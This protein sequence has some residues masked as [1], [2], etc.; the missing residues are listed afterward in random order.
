V[1]AGFAATRKRMRASIA[2]RLGMKYMP[3]LVF[4]HSDAPAREAE[5]EGLFARVRQREGWKP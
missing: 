3:E 1:E 4:L 2:T 5:M